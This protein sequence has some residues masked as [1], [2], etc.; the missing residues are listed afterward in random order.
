VIADR[1]K[2]VVNS[3]IPHPPQNS[4]SPAHVIAEPDWHKKVVR[5]LQ[6]HILHEIQVL[7][8]LVIGIGAGPSHGQI[9]P[10]VAILCRNRFGSRMRD[11]RTFLLL[12]TLLYGLPAASG[13][14]GGLSTLNNQE[15]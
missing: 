14:G 6:Y 12:S 1:H 15:L 2:K 9:L 4:G 7:R 10:D 5:I 11:L 8:I 3:R 13:G